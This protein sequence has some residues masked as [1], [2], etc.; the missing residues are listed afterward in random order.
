MQKKPE[1]TSMT[2]ARPPRGRGRPRAFDREAALAQAMRLFWIKGYEATSIADLTNALGVG[3]TS[4]YAAFGSKD[5]LYAEAMRLYSTT[6]EHLVLGRF[7]HAVTARE[8]AFAYLWDSAMAMTGADCGLPHGC[9]VTLAT[10]GSDGHA[11]LDD[12]MRATRGGAFDVLLSRL[13]RAVAEG[14]LPESLDI[15]QLA[16]FLQTVQSG[17]AIR[18]RDGAERAELQAVAEMTMAGWEELVRHADTRAK[19]D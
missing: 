1:K 11:E 17:M 13:E 18:A 16:R 5:E 8:A 12:L 19:S 14:E 9:M 3:S 15:A 4:L 10:V 2:I 6:Y 7:R